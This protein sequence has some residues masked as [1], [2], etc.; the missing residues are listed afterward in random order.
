M[1]ARL[2][3]VDKITMPYWRSQQKFAPLSPFF[4]L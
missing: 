2:N 1:Y 4:Y 3:L